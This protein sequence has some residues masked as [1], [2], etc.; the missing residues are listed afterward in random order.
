[1]LTSLDFS[2]LDGPTAAPERLR[3][4]LIDSVYRRLKEDLFEFRIAPGTRF[5]ENELAARLGVSRSPLRVALYMLAREGTMQRVDT[6]SGWQVRPL[7]FR[8][9]EELYELRVQLEIM[10]IRRVCDA[11]PFPDLNDLRE[12]WLVPVAERLTDSSKVAALDEAFHGSLV[13]AAGNRETLR[14]HGE[15]SDRIRIIRRLDFT[16]ASRIDA[17]YVE[18]GKLLRAVLARRRDSAELLLRSHIDASRAEIRHITLARLAQ[19]SESA[20]RVSA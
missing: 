11:D 13:R 16:V 19:A 4:N 3:R 2:A 1:M 6:H 14:V 8:Y 17:A 20:L 5:S 9:F 12:V 18:H 7:D 10:A 15:I